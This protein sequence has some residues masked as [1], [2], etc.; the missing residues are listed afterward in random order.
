[1]FL[2]NRFDGISNEGL[3]NKELFE[4]GFFCIECYEMSRIYFDVDVV[5]IRLENDI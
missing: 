3:R 2:K 5:E 4:K 1:M